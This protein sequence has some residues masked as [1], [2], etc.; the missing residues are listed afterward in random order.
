MRVPAQ[1]S[2]PYSF[3]GKFFIRE[4][5]SSQQM[6]REEI[7]EF[8]FKEGPHPDSTKH[9]CREVFDLERDLTDG[10]LLELGSLNEPGLPAEG[11]EP[12]D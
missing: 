4:G 1:Q 5:A 9:A 6:S 2:K 8:F 11:L 12:V 3:G 10:E 7:R